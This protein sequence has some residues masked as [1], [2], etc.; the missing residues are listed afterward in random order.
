MQRIGPEGSITVP[1]PLHDDLAIGTM[2]SIIRQ[3]GVSKS[4]FED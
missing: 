2:A 3:G 4:E 1:V